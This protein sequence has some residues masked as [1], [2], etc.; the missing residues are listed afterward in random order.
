M[1]LLGIPGL[2][3]A[4]AVPLRLPKQ[5]VKKTVEMKAL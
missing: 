4:L 3:R 5:P 1:L 2:R